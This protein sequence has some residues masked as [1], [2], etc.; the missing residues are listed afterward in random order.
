MYEHKGVWFIKE[1]GSEIWKLIVPEK[2][3]IPLMNSEH[4]RIGH[5]GVYKT[6]CQIR[7]NF[8]WRKLA[9]DV[10]GIVMGCDMCQRIK[11][12]NRSMEGEYGNVSSEHP[13]ELATVDFYGPLPRSV[14]GVE[15]IFVVL[16]AFSKLV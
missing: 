10:K 16:D 15:Y 3:K 11:H 7:R 6:I 9:R 12:L 13:G 8:W 1:K 14:G 2:L 4:E 5:G